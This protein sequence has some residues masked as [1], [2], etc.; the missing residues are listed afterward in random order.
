LQLLKEVVPE[1]SRVA[2]LWLPTNPGHALILRGLE[3]TAPTLGI[4]LQRLPVRGADEFE[5]SF[6]AMSKERAG[7]VLV[8]P[9]PMFTRERNRLADLAAKHRTPAVYGVVDH[10]AAGGLMAYAAD[11][12]DNWRRAAIYV[13]KIL[14]GAKPAD[15]PIEQP[16][17]FELVINLKTAKAL[18]LTIP[19]SL[20]LR[21]DQ[22]IE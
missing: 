10:A 15:L 9:E 14:K 12:R 22:V 2:V 6:A 13:D 16:T 5:A 1:V 21:A 19:P 18:G 4:T 11:D 3:A 17:K 7:G 20:L 8:L